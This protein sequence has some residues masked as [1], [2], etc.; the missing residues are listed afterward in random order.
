MPSNS[1]SL[2]ASVMVVLKASFNTIL[3]SSDGPNKTNER[4]RAVSSL[5]IPPKP[6]A[7]V[8][9]NSVFHKQIN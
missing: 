5:C 1:I 9:S 2:E 3:T 4:P 6:L 7:A 8:K